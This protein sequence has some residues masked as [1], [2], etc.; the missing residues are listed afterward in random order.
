MDPVRQAEIEHEMEQDAVQKRKDL[1]LSSGRFDE[2]VIAKYHEYLEDPI[3][4][5]EA[6]GPDGFQ[7]PCPNL[8]TIFGNCQNKTAEVLFE[9]HLACAIKDHDALELG[10][11]LLKQARHYLMR[12]A[13]DHV[14][15]NWRDYE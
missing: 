1:F 12:Q 14:E 10:E 6:L 11:A 15:L 8:N 2:R 3:R 9:A 5:W 7:A 13:S 4:L